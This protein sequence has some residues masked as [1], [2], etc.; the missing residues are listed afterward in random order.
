MN[1]P[2]APAVDVSNGT[3]LEVFLTPDEHRVLECV[4]KQ[5]QAEGICPTAAE[6]GQMLGLEKRIIYE[7]MKVLIKCGA[8]RHK[9]GQMRAWKVVDGVVVYRVPV[10]RR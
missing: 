9:K 1:Q 6:V 3:P 8:V 7:H 2:A 4:R 10:D 5:T